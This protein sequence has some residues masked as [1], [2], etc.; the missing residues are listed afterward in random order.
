MLE[1]FRE[2]IATF[3]APEVVERRNHFERLAN[4]DAL[5]GLANRAGYDRASGA[6]DANPN[7]FFVIFDLNDFGKVNKTAGHTAG[8]KI[9]IDYANTIETVARKFQARAFRLGGDEF[10]IICHRN[11]AAK[12]RDAVERRC[13]PVEFAGFTVSVSGE[14]GSTLLRADALLQQRKAI[15]KRI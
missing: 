9:L 5:T 4:I 13:L 8:D 10:V 12:A 6:A 2:K 15:R 11:F 1:T 7:L 14:I 3:I